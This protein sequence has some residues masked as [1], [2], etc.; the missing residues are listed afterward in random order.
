MIAMQEIETFPLAQAIYESVILA[1]GYPQVQMLSEKFRKSILKHGN[2]DQLQWVPEIEA[3][4]MDWCD[5]YINL[6]G[7]AN[8]NEF[9]DVPSENISINQTALG[10]ISTLRW[11]KTRWCV[12]R[13]PNAFF[14]QQAGVDEETMM[15][16]FF[17]ACLL[18]W[19]AQS[20]EWECW[21]SKIDNCHQ[22]QIIG[23]N[24]DL[25]FSIEG[26]K[27][28]VGDGRINFPDGEIMT[29]PLENTVNGNVFFEI[30]IYY[31]GRLFE[32]IFL[33]W[34]NGE[35]IEVDSSNNRELLKRILFSDQG[36]SKI[37][38]FAFGVNPSIKFFCKDIF[39]DEKIDHT[40]HIALG[41]SYPECGG[42]NQ[43]AIHWDIV[44]DLRND[45]CVII[46]GKAVLEGGKY[47]FDQ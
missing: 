1:G 47:H 41:R 13:V 21:A 22:I 15:N 5:V 33:S 40:V 14:A 9:W 34:K 23:K 29:S 37:G 43:S 39:F 3:H 17:D 25:S 19:K 7:A 45:G 35:L 20:E 32:N 12:V 27:W 42:T 8:P 6:R 46:D 36:A 31:G 4:A 18:D 38:E 28:V 26:R 10:K 16:M 11:Q 44:K 2:K 30:P 24:T